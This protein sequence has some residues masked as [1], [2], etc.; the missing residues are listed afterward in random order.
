M[1]EAQKW[2]DQRNQDLSDQEQIFITKSRE[3]QERLAREERQRQERESA[4]A[5]ALAEEQKKLA[6]AKEARA[7]QIDEQ[8]KL[9]NLRAQ[10]L[11]RALLNG[12]L[13]PAILQR[14]ADVVLPSLFQTYPP[15]A[16]G[17]RDHTPD[18]ARVRLRQRFN[19]ESTELLKI[20]P[21][22]EYAWIN[23]ILVLETAAELAFLVPEMKGQRERKGKS[24]ITRRRQAG[25]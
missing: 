7:Q 10:Q 6:V 1:S 24:A 20:S 19:K 5:A 8:I 15:P 13:D 23:F 12:Y 9:F 11:Y 18:D 4:K 14:A 25:H 21:A 16:P 17:V 22:T 3:L 2:F